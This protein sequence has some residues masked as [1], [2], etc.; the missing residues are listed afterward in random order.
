MTKTDYEAI[1]YNMPKKFGQLKRVNII[2]NP[3][4]TNKKLAMYVV[5]SDANDNLVVTNTA[6]KRN[7]VTWL[8]QYS[9]IN[10]VIEI[11]DAKIINFGINFELETDKRY[12]T[13]SVLFDATQRIKDKYTEKFYIGEP[14]YINDIFFNTK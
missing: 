14:I 11:F 3:F 12:D 2:N 7:L 5:S 13:T 10:D 8:N 6:T 4:A 1:S 9:S